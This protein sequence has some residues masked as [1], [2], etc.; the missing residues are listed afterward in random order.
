MNEKESRDDNPARDGQLEKNEPSIVSAGDMEDEENAAEAENREG[1]ENEAVTENAV[2]AD[3]AT[4]AESAEESADAAASAI[5]VGRG[6]GESAIGRKQA[7]WPW[8]AVAL[9]AIAALIFVLIRDN[10]QVAG[11]SPNE[12]VGRMDGATFTK[13]DLFD[14]MVKQLS[15]GQ[16]ASALD[17]LM[18]LKMLDL[19]ADKLG[20]EVTDRDIDA[21]IEKY[22]KNFSSDDEFNMA[23][24]MQG[25]SLDGLKEQ[26]AI[27]VKLRKIFEPQIAPTDDELRKF[28]EDHSSNYGTPEQ[29]RASHI[30]L[31][32]KEE[33]EAVLA[34]LKNGADFAALAKEKSID[35]GSKDQGGDLDYFGRGDMNEAFETAAFKLNAGEISGVVESPNGFH[36]IKVT[37]K[38][39][40]VTPTFD[41]VKQQVK[42]DYV[43]Q[44]IQSRI[45]DWLT[46]KK[47]EY[48]FQN[49]LEPPLQETGEP[50]AAASAPSSPSAGE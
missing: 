1:T 21:E 27:S 48:H 12:V 23:L 10:G 41:S 24:E 18:I 28:Y 42:D 2:K 36:I 25:L 9:L 20:I 33:A 11:G 14:D 31:E 38:K 17:N 26:I 35:P 44:E 46:A 50:D 6:D 19:E 8:I 32:T 34:E 40:A 29:I 39:A 22:K 49:L 47:K 15:E 37:D 43:D 16:A 4:D 3:N 5:A 30:L 7:P 13:V 45:Q